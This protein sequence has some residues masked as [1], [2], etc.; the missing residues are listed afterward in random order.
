MGEVHCGTNTLRDATA[1]WW[2][3]PVANRN[4]S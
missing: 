2:Q 1:A 3:R 4:E